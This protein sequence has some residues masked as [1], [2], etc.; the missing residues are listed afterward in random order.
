VKCKNFKFHRI[1]KLINSYNKY[2]NC[3]KNGTQKM[4][5]RRRRRIRRLEC[6]DKIFPQNINIYIMNIP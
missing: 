6:L 3:A 2:N 4:L 1:N 5:S